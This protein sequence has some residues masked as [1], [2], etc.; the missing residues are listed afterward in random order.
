MVQYKDVPSVNSTDFAEDYKV[1][2]QYQN[3]Y[4]FTNGCIVPL[5]VGFIL[6]LDG[7]SISNDLAGIL[8]TCGHSPRI[9]KQ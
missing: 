4:I 8:S 1:S 2:N 7:G 3:Y 6:D 5:V 9:C